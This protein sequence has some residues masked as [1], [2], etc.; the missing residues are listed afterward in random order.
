MIFELR[1]TMLDAVQAVV[2]CFYTKQPD[3]KTAPEFLE[4][5]VVEKKLE[6]EYIDKFKELDKLWKDIDHKEIKEVTTDHL[7]N[8]LRIS[9]QV[10]DRM[11]QLLPNDLCGEELPE[12][13][14]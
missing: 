5:L 12:T 10:I 14:D 8:A 7:N 11:K 6:K 3:Y 2:M 13:E 4:K 1:Y 9:R